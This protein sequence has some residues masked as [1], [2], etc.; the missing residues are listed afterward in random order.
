VVQYLDYEEDGE[1]IERNLLDNIN[2]YDN[3]SDYVVKMNKTLETMF[4]PVDENLVNSSEQTSIESN[5]AVVESSNIPNES[6]ESQNISMPSST[7][8]NVSL[9]SSPDEETPIIESVEEKVVEP[10]VSSSLDEKE[11]FVNFDVA[12]SVVEKEDVESSQTE[13]LQAQRHEVLMSMYNLK[14]EKLENELNHEYELFLQFPSLH[15][16]YSEE[17]KKFYL[18]QSFS[19][20]YRVQFNYLEAWKVHWARRMAE[21]KQSNIEQQQSQLK[22]M[23]KL[24]SKK[25]GFQDNFSDISEDELHGGT[26]KKV[27]KLQLNNEVHINKS[28]CSP[29]VERMI[30]AYNLA[31]EH[32]RS[33]KTLSIDDLVKLMESYPASAEEAEASNATDK[34]QTSTDFTDT[35]ILMLYVNHKNLS[36]KEQEN[37]VSIMTAIKLNDFERFKRLKVLMKEQ[38]T[39][40]SGDK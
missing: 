16:K 27:Q 10:A 8:Q 33:G 26:P 14:I 22:E 32:F 34:F 29:E 7:E 19:L 1:N 36:L 15:P 28:K 4:E 23:F 5:A 25:R 21:Y 12:P 2:P 11:F 24:D 18:E 6:E 13:L 35:E 30:F 17:W 38:N 31:L 20:A 3:T 37:F 9:L 39:K 40:T